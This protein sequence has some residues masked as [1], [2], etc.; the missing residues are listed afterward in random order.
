MDVVVR[1]LMSRAFADLSGLNGSRH[2]ATLSHVRD[3]VKYGASG[4][5]GARTAIEALRTD[6]VEAV[7]D[8]PERGSREV[9]GAEF[10]RM[11]TNGAQLAAAMPAEELALRVMKYAVRH[12]AIAANPCDAVDFSAS[13]A[14]GDKGAFEH[15]PLT[16]AEV[17]RLRAA[18]AG[19][20]AICPDTRRTR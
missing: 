19:E 7:W 12:R 8:D 9:A 4:L 14:T 1:D 5:A 16:A 13:R 6:F 3:L 20:V 17:G 15:R 11:E 10:D 2:D 18:I